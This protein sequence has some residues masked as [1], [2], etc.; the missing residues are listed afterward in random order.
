MGERVHNKGMRVGRKVIYEGRV[1]GVGF[2]YSTKQIAMGFDVVGWV[3]NRPDGRVELQAEGEEGEVD[4]FLAAMED[5]HLGGL[6][7][8]TEVESYPPSEEIKGFEIRS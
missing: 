1:Q 3:C 8:E 6:I 5:S 2:R 4:A 7:K